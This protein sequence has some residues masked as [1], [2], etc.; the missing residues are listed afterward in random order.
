MGIYRFY[1]RPSGCEQV[2]ANFTVPESGI[3][4]LL[5]SVVNSDGKAVEG[6][7]TILFSPE[8]IGNP[9]AMCIADSDGQFAFAPLEAEKLYLV[10][11]FCN[12]FKLRELQV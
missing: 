6:A 10:K 2:T 4:V 7:L 3:G 9:L 8:D 5:G 11:I 1:V 12:E